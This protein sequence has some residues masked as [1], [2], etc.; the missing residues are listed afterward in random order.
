MR[1]IED[2][3]SGVETPDVNFRFLPCLVAGLAYYIAQK[4]P[5]LMSR[6]PMLQTEYERQF[7][8]AAQE[9]REKA[10]LSLVPRIYGVR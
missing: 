6:V 5:E 7:D 2:A 4:D 3:G 10:T 1:R 9:D 8:L